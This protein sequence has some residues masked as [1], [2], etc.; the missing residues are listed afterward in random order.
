VSDAIIPQ[1]DDTP[2]DDATPQEV[3]RRFVNEIDNSEKAFDAYWKR[4]RK[5]NKRYLDERPDA[6]EITPKRKYNILWSNIQTAKPAVYSQTP[7]PEIERR[8]RDADPVG[9]AA[10]QML[11]RCSVYSLS[12]DDFDGKMGNSAL[13]YLL[14]GRA[15]AWVRYKPF[16]APMDE[17]K[18]P[19]DGATPDPASMGATENAAAGSDLADDVQSNQQL[20]YEEAPFDY[21]HREDFIHSIARSWNEVWWVARKVYLTRQECIERFGEE[22]GKKLQ[23]DSFPESLSDTERNSGKFNYMKKARIYELWCKSNRTVYWLSRNYQ[24]GYLDSKPD[25]LN[26]KDFFPCPRPAY[27]TIGNDTLIPTPDFAEYQDQADEMDDLSQRIKMLTKALKAAGVYDGSATGLK[28]LM[29]EGQDFTLIPIENWA[30]FA[31]KGGING[32]VSW[33]PVD[34]VSK[35]L[36]DLFQAR[37]A[38]KQEIYEITGFS[39][40]MRG[41]SDAS[42]TATAQNIKSQYGS[43][44]LRDK[45]KEIQRFARDILRLKC[46]IIAEHFSPQTLQLM[47]N[48]NLPS[49]PTPE[50]AQQYQQA[51]MAAQQQ[52]APP[53]PPLPEGPYIEDV[54]A[55]LRNDG[56]RGFRIDIETD[57]TILADQQQE[58]Q[59]RTEFLTAVGSFLTAAVPL[60]EQVP[61]I[62]PLLGQ[63]LMFGVRG[64]GGSTRTLE[65]PFEDALSQM[66]QAA[67]Q[68]QPP[69]VDPA[70]QVAQ[71]NAKTDEAKQAA[72]QQS[73]QQKLAANQA[74]SQEQIKADLIKNQ[75]Q[76]QADKEKHAMSIDADLQ[77]HQMTT[78]VNE[79]LGQ[80][81]LQASSKPA[82][83][84]NVNAEDGLTNIVKQITDQFGVQQ[85]QQQQSTEM[86]ASALTQLGA[87][88]QQALVA[89]NAPKQ[90]MRGPDGKVMGVSTMSVQ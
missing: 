63:M 79:R 85:Q 53:P 44:R 84:I 64:F 20:A 19:P 40:I 74:Q 22:I 42:E 69:K 41:A 16:F 25:W 78:A 59:L 46:E 72:Q 9:R 6:N 83:N 21:I 35:V 11:E 29:N 32:V 37:D 60:G 86:I 26:L 49:K 43:M 73:D 38:C 13:D 88:I 77:K 1:F 55:L 68:P 58:K 30:M 39:D 57:S 7:K 31:E 89:M 70:V 56:L 23:L 71:I 24:D 76:I 65:Q 33:W 17:T 66:E 36:I 34:Q 75:A 28:E 62:M 61:A 81:K 54:I 10:S 12:C 2:L 67:K 47:S 3:A 15:C 51:S 8:F 5:I 80:Q 50:Q 52:G 18:A 90:V 27:G 87:S 14:F 82:A 48:L 45:Q 4:C